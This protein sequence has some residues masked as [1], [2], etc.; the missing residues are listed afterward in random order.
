MTKINKIIMNGFKS[1]GKRTEILFG[2]QF[3]VILGPNG[4]GKSN[5][6]DALC[7]VLGKGSAKGL[8]VEKSSNLIYNGGKTKKPAKEG[9]VSIFFDNSNKIFPTEEPVVKISRI[10]KANGQSKYKINNKTRTKQQILDLLSIAKIEPDG[11]NIILQGDIVRF[12]EMHPV[13]KRQIVEEIAGISV[14]EDKK[15]KALK[16]LEKVDEKI[17]EADIVLKERKAYLKELKKDRDQAQRYKDLNDQIRQNKASYLKRQIIR[18]ES[19]E[20][21]QQEK[22]DKKKKKLDKHK[23]EI[24]A[25]RGQISERKEEIKRISKQAEERGDVE[26]V[27]LQK[28]IERLRVEIA[29]SKTR[30]ANCSNEI[31]RISQ[32]REQLRKNVSE[33]DEKMG[34]LEQKKKEIEERKGVLEEQK[35]SMEKSIA[36]FKKKHKIGDDHDI[37]KELDEIDKKADDKQTE[38]QK[39]R[40]EQ[41]ELLREKDRLEMQVQMMDERISKVLEVEK[42]HKDELE[43]LKQKKA[44]FKKATVE[45]NELLNKDSESAANLAEQRK[46][47]LKLTEELARLEA[48]SI[49]AKESA[50]ESIAVKKILSN[51]GKF[52][53]I[54][55]GTVS[56]LGEAN[57]KYAAALGVAA[58]RKINSIVVEND[59]VAAKCIKFLKDNKFG[60]ASFLPVN[61]MKPEDSSVSI[62]PKKLKSTKGAHGKAI[63]LIEFEPKFKNVFR[64]VFGDTIIVDSIEVARRIGIGS[65]KMVT[66]DGD[67]AEQSGAMTGGYR[68][69]KARAGFRE[70]EVSGEIKKT[71]ERVTKLKS[72]MLKNESAKSENEARITNL[73]EFKA[74]L[75]GEII[76]TEK[77][78]HLESGDLEA[79]KAIKEQSEKKIADVSKK[80]DDVVS[81]VSG[82]NKELAELKIRKQQ[83]RDKFNELR[84]PTLIAELNSFEEKKRQITEQ[85][86]KLEGEAKSID[87]QSSDILGRDKDSTSKILKDINKEEEAFKSEIKDLN[88]IIKERSGILKQM[89]DKQNEF[90]TKFKGLF[91][92]INKLNDDN[93]SDEGNLYKVEESGRKEE[94]EINTLSLEQAKVRAELSGLRE[95]FAQYEGVELDMKKPEEQ[96]KKEISEFEK[97]RENIGS[98]N[99]RA[100]EIY[101]SVEKEY[102]S[103]LKKKES[104]GNEKDDVVNLIQEIDSKKKDIFMN[105]FDV[106]S[107]N[108]QDIFSSLSTKG[109][110][111]LSLEDT[112]DPFEGGLTV[113]VRLTGNKFLDIRSLSG[114]EKTLTALAFIFAIQEHEPAS[115]YILDEVDA[116][117]DK[118][119]SE[120]L[121]KLIRKYSD[122]AQYVIISH[123]DALISEADNLYGVSMDEHSKSNVVSLKI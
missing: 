32:R 27:S 108:F 44:E 25:L 61:K 22:I 31:A 19:A 94:I 35:K 114:G 13:E 113:N 2:N 66:V 76:K 96:L 110:A 26:Q 74:N 34:S 98:V 55:Y 9:E 39:L 78:L 43:K 62:S 10:V 24:K 56:E 75:E 103:L 115:F 38:V 46:E 86:L 121:A 68:N 29:T 90:Q 37:S 45:L 18:K 15:Q 5:V 57:S 79:S 64:Y 119:N 23:E 53:G 30:A 40:E 112:E 102:N 48:R 33:I 105:T 77:G 52:G 117:L 109:E 87:M 118:H 71:N 116:A 99:M 8:R 104:L 89:E 20:Q 16:E 72:E 51:K 97:M 42:E 12:V 120:K 11:Y 58:G 28:E 41:Q 6:L 49:T 85:L 111:H 14:Y 95:D 50:A 3:N 100:L 80:L 107:K 54:V 36:A 106:V 1:F 81:K 47:L 122:N 83:L 7:F 4:S 67:I 101:E 65:A 91:E 63:D 82:I 123:N 73:R 69:K 60:V 92:K 21:S 84:K 93:S 88:N 70:K 59:G 17:N